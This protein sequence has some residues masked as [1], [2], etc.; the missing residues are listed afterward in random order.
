VTCAAPIEEKAQANKAKIAFFMV[1]TCIML[2]QSWLWNSLRLH[3]A[4]LIQSFALPIT[5]IPMST[6]IP[7]NTQVL[8]V[9]FNPKENSGRI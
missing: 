3:S 8:R 1:A 6:T 9:V 4:T 7:D 2:R 5:P